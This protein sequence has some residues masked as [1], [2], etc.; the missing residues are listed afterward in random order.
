MSTI[1]KS[2]EM[3][4]NTNKRTVTRNNSNYHSKKDE[5]YNE[6]KINARA[7]GSRLNDKSKLVIKNF[8]KIN[9]HQSCDSKVPL[10]C[11]RENNKY[12]NDNH[13]RKNKEI[14]YNSFNTNISPVNKKSRNDYKEIVY[15]IMNVINRELDI[16]VEPDNLVYEVKK[17]IY[18]KEEKSNDVDMEEF[19]DA[20]KYKKFCT[21][22]MR[23]NNINKFE[24]FQAYITGLTQQKDIH[25]KYLKSLKRI[26]SEQPESNI[27]SKMKNY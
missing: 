13:V 2:I 25:N 22:V 15:N 16:D 6:S 5:T 9:R 4:S 20:M 17:M 19:N 14:Q 12:L 10:S 3:L 23:K 24:D 8:D 18:N 7:F 1:I 11:P 27:R 21:S 26:L